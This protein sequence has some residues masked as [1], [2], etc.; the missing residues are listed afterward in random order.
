V[1]FFPAVCF[2]ALC[3]SCNNRN[4]EGSSR[5]DGQLYNGLYSFKYNQQHAT[6]HNILCY[7]Q[8]ST[9]FRRFLRPSSGAQNCTHSICYMSILLATTA[10]VV[11]LLQPNHASGGRKQVWHV[12]DA[13]STVFELLMMGGGN[14]RKMYSIGSNKEFCITVQKNQIFSGRHSPEGSTRLRLAE[15]LENHYMKLA[16][17]TAPGS[18]NIYQPEDTAGTHLC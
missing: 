1:D 14:A 7:C 10:S 5:L 3:D 11:G 17:L 16:S 4:W 18:C 12:V 8:C 13:V 9:C 2:W 6:L 15:F